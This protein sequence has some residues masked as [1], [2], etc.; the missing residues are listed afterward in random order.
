MRARRSELDA[1]DSKK[2]FD[3]PYTRPHRSHGRFFLMVMLPGP[4]GAQMIA[5]IVPFA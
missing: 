3:E 1:K 5:T 4:V 2:R